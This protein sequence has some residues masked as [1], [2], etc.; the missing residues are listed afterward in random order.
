[1]L[2]DNRCDIASGDAPGMAA[3]KMLKLFYQAGMKNLGRDLAH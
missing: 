1:V 3:L 2:A